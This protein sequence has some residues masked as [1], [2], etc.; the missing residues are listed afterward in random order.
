MKMRNRLLLLISSIMLFIVEPLSAQMNYKGLIFSE[1]YLD[2]SRPEQSWL[3]I[4]NPTSNPLI[5]ENAIK[6]AKMMSMNTISAPV[7]FE[8]FERVEGEFDYTEIDSLINGARKAELKLII[9]WFGS[10][11]NG[12]SNYIPSWMKLNHDKY[13]MVKDK[14]GNMT[15]SLSP[16]FETTL[17][18]DKTAFI[19][20]LSHIKEIDKDETVIGI[21]IENE[22][23]L[24]GTVRDYSD[25]GNQLFR[26]RV[27]KE[28]ED[29]SKKKGSWSKVFGFFSEEFF[30]AY[31]IAKFIDEIASAGK[32]ILDLPMYVNVW[33]GEMY[34]RIPG[35]SYPSG[36]AVSHVFSFFKTMAPN[37]DAIAPDI[38]LT[39]DKTDEELFKTYSGSNNIF[40]LPESAP[41]PQFLV[42]GFEAI[43]NYNL[44]G[45]HMFGVDMMGI[46]SSP[47]VKDLSS[48]NDPMI[49]TLL[50]L[51]GEVMGAFKILSNMKPLIE[52]Y[53]ESGKLYA[54][55]Q[56]E[57]MVN[58]Y[59]DF[60]DYIGIIK[61]L[62]KNN[63]LFSTNDSYNMDSR[64]YKAMYPSYRAKGFIVNKGN[65]EFY[66]AGDAFSLLLYKKDNLNNFMSIAHSSP[67]FQTR[68]SSFISV[69]EGIFMDNGEYYPTIIRNGDE[70]DGGFWVT[71]DI[72]VLHVIME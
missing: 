68:T 55:A 59:I 7:H 71:N 39:D 9:L 8:L 23:G 51:A 30:T 3:E 48:S 12:V 56:K 14:A 28:V 52:Q 38:Y 70:T 50:P 2:E 4:Y 40:Y 19:A 67:F 41:L 1:V 35:V 10:W 32:K 61:F 25:K 26:E 18:A 37:L 21:Q 34:E 6:A 69:T 47:M 42:N 44:T 15:R 46:L 54:I 29:F 17:E 64:H 62:N 11:K 53:Q 57:G 24:I 20:L 5:L 33:L 60:G 65:G 16:L 72:G 36:G 49:K 66:L 13:P 22:P 58:Q 63:S 45:F 27:P 43:A 31:Y